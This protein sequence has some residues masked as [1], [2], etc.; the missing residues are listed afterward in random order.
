MKAVTVGKP[1]GLSGENAAR[2]ITALKRVMRHAVTNLVLFFFTFSVGAFVLNWQPEDDNAGLRGTAKLATPTPSPRHD[3]FSVQESPASPTPV[4]EEPKEIIC[5]HRILEPIW[6]ILMKGKDFRESVS[7][8]PPT[9]CEE[10]LDVT[11]IDVNGDGL[12]EIFLWAK[13]AHFCG[14]VGNCAFWIFQ[15]RGSKYW[16][17]LEASDYID[18]S[19]MGEQLLRTKS[20]GYYDILLKGHLSGAETSFSY[21]KF[22]GRRYVE[23]RCMYEVPK[24]D[25]QDHLSWEMITCEEFDRRGNRNTKGAK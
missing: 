19:V 16:M 5:E 8:A 9:Y 6:K 17:L 1:A 11:L 4:E 18:R 7:Y 15:K 21:Y 22:N 13:T 2:A 25:R 10:V 12:P 14:A 3:F 20:Q 23:T 24:Y